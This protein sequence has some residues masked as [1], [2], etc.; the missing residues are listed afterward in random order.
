MII[1]IIIIIIIIRISIAPY[2]RAH[3]ALH[4]QLNISNRKFCRLKK[5]FASIIKHK[6]IKIQVKSSYLKIQI[7]IQ[8]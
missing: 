6:Y 8:D 2:P 4:L 5:N 3:G 7:Q 1:I